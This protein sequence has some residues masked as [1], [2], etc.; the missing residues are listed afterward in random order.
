MKLNWEKWLLGMWAAFAGGGAGGVV[1][2][3]TAMGIDPEN[4]NLKV[5]LG[6]TMELFGISFVVNGIVAMFFY[7]KQSPVPTESAP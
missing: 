6:H 3:L 4:F 5:G 7:L 2:S 1:N